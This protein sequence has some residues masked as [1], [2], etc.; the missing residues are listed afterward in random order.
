MNILILTIPI[1]LLLGGSFLASFLWAV[2]QGQFDDTQTPA[3]RIL[4]DDHQRE[5][6]S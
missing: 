6:Q 4:I 1:A 3:V 2:K 5:D